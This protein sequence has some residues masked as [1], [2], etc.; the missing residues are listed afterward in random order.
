[1]PPRLEI[2]SPEV[3]QKGHE[4]VHPV[5]FRT[6]TFRLGTFSGPTA[7]GSEDGA[8]RVW[9]NTEINSLCDLEVMSMLRRFVLVLALL[10]VCLAGAATAAHQRAETTLPPPSFRPAVA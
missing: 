2:S 1:M 6:L 7:V 5:A 4:W 3:T 9:S 8:A 10:T